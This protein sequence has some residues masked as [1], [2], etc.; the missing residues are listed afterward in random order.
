MGN[1]T[2]KRLTFEGALYLESEWQENKDLEDLIANEPTSLPVVGTKWPGRNEPC[3]C[4]SGK[5]YK[6][7]CL[8]KLKKN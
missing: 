7:C 5:K 2:S 4:G 8:R 1:G 6:K 3:I